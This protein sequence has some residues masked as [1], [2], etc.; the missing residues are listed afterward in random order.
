[1]HIQLATH[2]AHADTHVM[3]VLKKIT[4]LYL[5]SKHTKYTFSLYILQ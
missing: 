3:F 2:H 1:M 5:L 4:E